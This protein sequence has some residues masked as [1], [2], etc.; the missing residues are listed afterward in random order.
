ML[1][2]TPPVTTSSSYVLLR[3]ARDGTAPEPAKV[4]RFRLARARLDEQRAPRA[5]LGVV[6]K[7]AL[8][9]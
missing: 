6:R 5:R 2:M 8:H 4:R 7:D 9:A 1:V 3:A